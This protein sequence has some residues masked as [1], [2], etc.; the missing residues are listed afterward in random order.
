MVIV[1]TCFYRVLKR[2][3]LNGSLVLGTTHSNKLKLIDLQDN[4]I[5]ELKGKEG[6]NAMLM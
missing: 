3:Q 2:N 4:F 1:L 5:S 6:Y